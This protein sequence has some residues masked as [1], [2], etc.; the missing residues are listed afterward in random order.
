METIRLF[1]MQCEDETVAIVRMPVSPEKPYRIERLYQ[2]A[3]NHHVK[4]L[5][6]HEITEEELPSKNGKPDRQFRDAWTSDG[7]KILFNM[8][9]VRAIHLERL[10]FERLPILEQLDKD[11]MR[12]AGRGKK[13]EADA[14]EAKREVLRNFPQDSA[15]AFAAAK[16]PEEVAAIKLPV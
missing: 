1:A 8:D 9:K 5:H 3:S 11:W 15:S 10:R 13:D 6:I 7:T 14:I 2:A 12:A 16:T 4:V